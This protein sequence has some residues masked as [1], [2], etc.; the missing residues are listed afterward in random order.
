M[1]PEKKKSR[2]NQGIGQAYHSESDEQG[3]VSFPREDEQFLVAG[4]GKQTVLLDKL[5]ECL[6]GKYT[7][8]T[9][10]DS[11][12]ILVYDG[13]C[14]VYRKNGE[15]VIKQAMEETLLER[16]LAELAT[17]YN[18][19]EVIEHIRRRTYIDREE[20]NKENSPFVNVKNGLLNLVEA[21]KGE[22]NPLKP[23]SSQV[24]TTIQLPIEYN[25]KATCP[26]ISKFLHEIV[27]EKDVPLLEEIFGWCLLPGYR[28]QRAVILLGEGWNG[29]STYINLVKAFLGKENCSAVSLQAAC[30]NRFAVAILYGK[31]ANL[32]ADLSS[33]TIRD[34][35]MFKM[36]T[37][38]DTISA[39]HKFTHPFTFVNCVKLIFSANKPPQI[40]D[41]TM[42]MWRRV[43]AIG[44]P[45]QFVGDKE[46]KGL[47][48]KLTTQDELSGL[49]N[50]AITG[51]QR[52]LHQKE[53]TYSRSWE[54]TREDYVR[55][56][57]PLQAFVEECCTLG[58]FEYEG[59]RTYRLDDCPPATPKETLYQS[60]L[61]Y[62]QINKLA[63]ESKKGFGRHLK[64][65]YKHEIRE[66]KKGWVGIY[67]KD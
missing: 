43:M 16:R 65:L 15:T 1:K 14:G 9:L 31:L 46:V 8:K 45:N 60:Y 63:P 55:C 7:F 29:K 21:I 25:P 47:I 41:D 67:I 4:K 44:F 18:V 27:A 59:G 36:L 37:G 23:H 48:Y 28:F 33:A 62:C 34:A 20:V 6:M 52:L 40:H 61:V 10:R 17:R 24:I 2:P 50:V 13:V 57:N 22:P 49:L 39:E 58:E 32:C 12:E 11:G 3:L 19:S 42:A 56:S 26:R 35:G 53:F 54:E 5:A 64:S 30:D 51:L 38:G 66:S